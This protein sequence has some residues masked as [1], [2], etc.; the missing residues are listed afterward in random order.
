[1]ERQKD[2]AATSSKIMS[3]EEE[4]ALDAM[5]RQRR[6]RGMA[7]YDK[8]GPPSERELV[9]SGSGLSV[10]DSNV[11]NKRI[12]NHSSRLRIGYADTIGKRPTMEDEIVIHGRLRGAENEDFVAV[13]DGHGGRSASEYAAKNLHNILVQK[14]NESKE[15][16]ESLRY[17]FINTNEMMKKEGIIG[18]TTAIAALFLKDKCYIANAGDSRAVL[19]KDGKAYRLSKDHKPEDP[20]EESRIIKA[21]GTVLKINNTKLG[22]TIGRVNG[23][24]SVSRALGDVFLQPY[25]S[26]EP[27]VKC[28][29]VASP[30]NQLLILACD[31][32]W[33]VVSDEEAVSIACS[34]MDPE[35]AAIKLRDTALNKLSA[36]NVSV[37]VI[38]LP[39][40]DVIFVDED[41]MDEKKKK[42]QPPPNK[43]KA[44]L[45]AAAAVFFLFAVLRA[46]KWLSLPSDED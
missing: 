13:Y 34:E 27:D 3:K 38:L 6:G 11:T 41:L 1:M 21:G 19:G 12:L 42:V 2:V 43:I 44:A 25:V 8:T 37:V 14:L 33:D 22:K 5:V 28:I 30:K 9:Y 32:L 40:N 26:A 17:A 18:G 24:L 39:P 46:G 4:E 10:P 29:N 16:E 20:E 23:M 45:I 31:G 15:P 7:F 36:D 35:K